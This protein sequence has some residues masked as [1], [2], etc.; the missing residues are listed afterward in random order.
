MARQPIPIELQVAVNRNLAG[1][2]AVV[3]KA[4]SFVEEQTRPRRMSAFG[5]AAGLAGLLGASMGGLSESMT[6]S[7]LALLDT[8][9]GGGASGPSTL[10][11]PGSVRS[12]GLGDASNDRS[13]RS[14]GGS[15]RG[16]DGGAAEDEPTDNIKTV[17]DHHNSISTTGGYLVNSIK[18][19]RHRVVCVGGG[20]WFFLSLV[21]SHN[22][23]ARCR[24]PRSGTRRIALR[25][26]SETSTCW[27]TRWNTLPIST[28]PRCVC[29]WLIAA[30]W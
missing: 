22:R 24:R 2:V 21:V 20:R 3:E 23:R 26:V 7:G 10:A 4:H 8:G 13:M 30:V 19:S 15:I 1:V 11:S 6:R 14:M 17:N 27:S 28:M 29:R 16:G 9:R 25:R 5:P 18:V 12:G